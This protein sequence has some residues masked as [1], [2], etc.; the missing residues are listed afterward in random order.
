MQSLL[1]NNKYAELFSPTD[2]DVVISD[3]A[4][5]SIN[6]N[7]RDVFNYFVGYKLGLTATPRNYLRNVDVNDHSIQDPREIERRQLMDTYQTFGCESGQPT[8]RYSLVDGANDG[9]LIN[10]ES[11]GCK[12]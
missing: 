5:R 9:F 7:A 4:H 12:D 10:P 6:G 3:E 2:F 8:F 11:C 1:V